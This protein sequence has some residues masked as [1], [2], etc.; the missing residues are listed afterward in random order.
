MVLVAVEV[1]PARIK[2]PVAVGVPISKGDTD[3]FGAA[4]PLPTRALF[5]EQ[6]RVGGP[7]KSSPKL[8]QHFGSGLTR[9]AKQLSQCTA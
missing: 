8:V 2:L 4:A 6:G 3:D 1:L 7:A 9:F 5:L